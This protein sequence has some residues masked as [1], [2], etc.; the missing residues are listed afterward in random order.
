MCGLGWLDSLLVYAVF[1]WLV[2]FV[3][4][5]LWVGI[6]RIWTGQSVKGRSADVRAVRGMLLPAL[7][8]TLLMVY[9]VA[10]Y[11]RVDQLPRETAESWQPFA[12]SAGEFAQSSLPRRSLGR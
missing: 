12:I 7:I 3:L 5:A 9:V 2:W 6:Q 4:G 10:C 1:F 8:L 11:H